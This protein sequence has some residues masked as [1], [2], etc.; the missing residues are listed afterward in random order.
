[1]Y[2][3]FLRGCVILNIWTKKT[4]Y[5]VT[6]EGKVKNVSPLCTQSEHLYHQFL[7]VP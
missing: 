2:V 7:V 4:E 6:Q 1:M 3:F 5:S